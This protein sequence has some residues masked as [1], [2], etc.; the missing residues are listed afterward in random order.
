MANILFKVFLVFVN[1]MYMLYFSKNFRTHFE[2]IYFFVGRNLSCYNT[3]TERKN[4]FT[5]ECISKQKFQGQ[6]YCTKWGILL[7]P[8]LLKA[9]AYIQSAFPSPIQGNKG[10]VGFL[11]RR[12]KKWQKS[13][14]K[15][16]VSIESNYYFPDQPRAKIIRNKLQEAW[17]HFMQ[18]LFLLFL[19]W[20]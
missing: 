3:K 11:G 1:G 8:T 9:T 2:Y 17:C 19:V 13:H 6:L 10:H 18:P 16:L 14:F 4:K 7:F 15:E 12:G 5:S 20:Y